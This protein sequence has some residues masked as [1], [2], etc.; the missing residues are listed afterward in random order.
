M[1]RFLKYYLVITGIAAIFALAFPGLM[2]ILSYL[3]VGLIIALAPTAFLWGC[4]LALGLGVARKVVSP[5][6]ARAA[7]VAFTALILWMVPQ[8]SVMAARS[9]LHRFDLQ[10][11]TPAELIRLHGD[12]R[13]DTSSPEQGMPSRDWPG[14]PTY[15]CDLRCIA[16][17]FEPG[18][19]SVTMTR[20]ELPSFEQVRKDSSRPDNSSR[21]YRL[22]P[23]AQC[24]SEGIE[25]D[26][27]RGNNRFGATIEDRRAVKADWSMK[28]ETQY[29][30]MD[31][32]PLD[33]YDM[34][35]RSGSW[36]SSG[37]SSPGSAPF[38][39]AG[40][41]AQANFSDVLNSKGEVLF[42]RFDL[43]ADALRVPLMILPSGEEFRFGWSRRLLPRGVSTDWMETDKAVD[44][45]IAVKRSAAIGNS[46]SIARQAVQEVFL[47]SASATGRSA[48][49]L[50]LNY[51]EMLEKAQAG[52]EDAALVESLLNDR[53]L[54]DLP[55]AWVLHRSF[56]PEQLNSF[57]PAIINKLG[58]ETSV[59]P[60]DENQL[61]KALARWPPDAFASPDN[62]TLALLASPVA[63][64][65]AIGLVA[66]MSDM[67]ER[68]APLLADIIEYHLGVE[69]AG[70][71]DLRNRSYLQSGTVDAGI[72][73]MCRLGPQAKN[74]LPRMRELEKR[75]D[76][77]LVGR[78][79][80]QVMM[81]RLG[82]PIDEFK[83]PDVSPEVEKQYIST[84][85]YIAE[86]FDPDRHCRLR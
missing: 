54:D 69:P 6:Y 22:M 28:F 62:A 67:G 8:L 2:L 55:G 51:M 57:L 43:A 7:A 4:I 18:V 72:S 15:R 73:A 16:I 40:S 83:R 41:T 29:C 33:R 34:L 53:R 47:D 21:T 52:P 30:L 68:G 76:S 82:K 23:K 77:Y 32:A 49:S 80:W 71:H 11:V 27:R 42:R 60:T 64:L 14:I 78:H 81:L 61:G 20:T 24:G 56:T 36:Q 38:S 9:A 58:M 65:R 63:R 35:L 74:Q 70:P 12:V 5:A 86:T 46:L 44:D 66:R 13:I 39:I 75:L 3:G 45:A 25:F 85:K 48:S 79:E 59:E 26:H 19:R 17:L 1:D 31:E 10:N 84:L 50:I 37:R